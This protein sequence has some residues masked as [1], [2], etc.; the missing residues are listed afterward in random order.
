MVFL[1]LVRMSTLSAG[2]V[3]EAVLRL[4]EKI[5]VLWYNQFGKQELY[6]HERSENGSD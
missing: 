5:I 4:L 2:T 6:K 3:V 1:F